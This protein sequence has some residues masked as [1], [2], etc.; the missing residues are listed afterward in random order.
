MF[1]WLPGRRRR[2][3][4]WY[5]IPCSWPVT[6]RHQ[7]RHQDGV[8]FEAAVLILLD[9][10][11]SL[12]MAQNFKHNSWVCIQHREIRDLNWSQMNSKLYKEAFMEIHCSSS[13]IVT[14]PHCGLLVKSGHLKEVVQLR[15][16][17]QK[18]P[19]KTWMTDAKIIL[20]YTY[21]YR[22]SYNK[23]SRVGL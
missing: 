20:I 5:S 15:C 22:F 7:Y 2:N 13:I 16:G 4:Y 8:L 19:C 6:K 11:R 17:I 12:R 14:I 23:N 1:C 9:P 10:D 3:N 18:T 21:T